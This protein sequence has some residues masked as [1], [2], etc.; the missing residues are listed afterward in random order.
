LEEIAM[1]DRPVTDEEGSKGGA[2]T[3]TVFAIVAAILTV[4]LILVATGVI[5]GTKVA[6]PSPP[7]NT[8]SPAPQPNTESPAKTNP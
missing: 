7:P 4:L 6:S 8:E 2:R 1:A 3:V 5:T